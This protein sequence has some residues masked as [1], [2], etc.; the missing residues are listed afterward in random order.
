MYDDTP[1]Y[2]DDDEDVFASL[3]KAYADRD[4]EMCAFEEGLQ[5]MNNM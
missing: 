2:E 1:T 5:V 4:S 3:K